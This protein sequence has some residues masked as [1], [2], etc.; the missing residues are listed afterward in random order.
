M[1]V[2]GQYSVQLAAARCVAI[3]AS[4]RS[5]SSSGR[6]QIER[7]IKSHAGATSSYL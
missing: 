5:I 4:G 7:I 1:I 6:G 2:Q 3:V